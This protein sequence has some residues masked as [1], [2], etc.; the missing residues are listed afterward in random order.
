[1]QKTIGTPI[2]MVYIYQVHNGNQ[3]AEITIPN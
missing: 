3:N 2:P 1:M